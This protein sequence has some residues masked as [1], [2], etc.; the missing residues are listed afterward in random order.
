MTGDGRVVL[1]TATAEDFDDFRAVYESIAA[2][3]RWIGG[4]LPI[5]WEARR[6]LW[7]ASWTDPRWF[8]LLA[9]VEDRPVGWISAEH[10]AHARVSVGMGLIDGYRSMGIGSQLLAAAVGWAK[11]RGAH[12]VLLELW[13]HN[14]RAL[15]L[16]R[17]FGFEVEGRH[18]RHWRRNDGSLW[19]CVSMGLVLDEES[20]GGP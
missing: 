8:V 9:C 14:D 3:G 5:D 16:Y 6:P 10:D 11:H 15:G 4:E 12:K 7:E 17:K 20:P 1:R 13:P 18:R 2:E 19:D